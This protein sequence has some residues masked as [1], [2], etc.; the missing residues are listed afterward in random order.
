[1]A[2]EYTPA[3]QIIHYWNAQKERAGLA[4]NAG[5]GGVLGGSLDKFIE[6]HGDNALDK[7]KEK[8]D[9]KLSKMIE[10]RKP[11][12]PE[13]APQSNGEAENSHEDVDA[14]A[15][16]EIASHVT[17]APQESYRLYAPHEVSFSM[18]TATGIQMSY[19]IRADSSD[20]L[21]KRVEDQYRAC[22]KRGYKAMPT[23]IEAKSTPATHTTSS[24]ANSADSGTAECTNIKVAQTFK[25]PKKPLLELTCDGFEHPLKITGKTVA[26]QVKALSGIRTIKGQPFVESDFVLGKTHGGLWLVDW[27]KEGQ[28]HNVIAIRPA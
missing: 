7:A 1:M 28:Y 14:R 18:F 22:D 9:A 13:N 16:D 20:E 4:T 15:T 6:A 19:T 3:E 26:D 5:I 11:A 24:T 10:A 21:A 12:E 2:A 8:I 17:Y 27:K 23:P 25:E